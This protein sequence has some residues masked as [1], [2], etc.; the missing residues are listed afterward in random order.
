MRALA[1]THFL[2]LAFALLALGCQRGDPLTAAAIA[3]A[4]ATWQDYGVDDYQLELDI[5][6]DL[7]EEGK[8][9]ISV[10]D[11]RVTDAR[12]N[13]KTISTRDPFYTV[14]GLFKFLRDEIEMAQQ[15][16]LY[17]QAGPGTNIYQRALFD[18][19]AGYLKRYLR[20]VTGTKHNIKIRVTR[21]TAR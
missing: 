5:E 15:P 10:Q 18:A 6:G 13:G 9:R 7:V 3:Q 21:L 19:R 1:L 11:G 14:P 16:A 17:W 8:F 2:S 4:E 20:A 12:R